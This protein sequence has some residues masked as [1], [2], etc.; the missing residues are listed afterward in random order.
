MIRFGILGTARVARGLF[1]R[2]PGN[3]EIIAIASRDKTQADTFGDEFGI[4]RRYGSYLDL[5]ADPDIQA[6]YIPLPQH[7]H[8]EYTVKAAQAGKHVLV[9]KP[10]ALSCQE[11]TEMLDAC[12]SNGVLFMEAF[13]YRFMRVHNRAKEIVQNGTIGRLRYIDF[14]FGFHVAARGRIGFRM[15]KELG[16][17]ALYDLGIYGMDFLRFITDKEPELLAAWTYRQDSNSIDEFTH[18]VYRIDEVVA[19]ITCSFNTDANY[20]VLSG[21]R[22]SISSPVAISG[23]SLPNVLRVHLLEEE[24]KYEEYFPPENPYAAEVEY[25]VR[26]IERGEEP[27]LGGDNSLR[28]MQLLENLL[29]KATPLRVE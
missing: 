10:A 17:G 3:A 24:N 25:F 21:E 27:F 15:Q 11:L 9:E 20:Y 16:G 6:V 26:C 2:R 8:R 22:G 4:P 13:M 29:Q 18:A 1:G 14:N 7:L 23:R 19:T 28:D 5:L 12:R